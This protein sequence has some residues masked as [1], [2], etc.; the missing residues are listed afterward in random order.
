MFPFKKKKK[1]KKIARMRK[2]KNDTMCESNRYKM[3]E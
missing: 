3:I 1:K 2:W